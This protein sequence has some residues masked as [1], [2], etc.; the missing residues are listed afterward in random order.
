VAAG[1][2]EDAIQE[3]SMFITLLVV[4]FAIALLVTHVVAIAFNKSIARIL[5]RI[6]GEPIAAA[7]QRYVTF[8]I[9][10][11]GAPGGVRIWELEKYISPHG[12]DEPALTLNMDRWV[13]EVYRTIIETLQSTAWLLL[14]FF[15]VALFA[16]IIVRVSERG[17]RAA[18]TRPQPA[19]S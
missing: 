16:Y 19:T 14:V 15:G 3:G 7:W 2:L 12:K 5:E 9:Y 8:G 13:L 17:T 11:V 18:E 1:S 10:V 4:T 6:F